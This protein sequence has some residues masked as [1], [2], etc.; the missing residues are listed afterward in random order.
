[1]KVKIE[2]SIARGEIKAP[3]SKSYAHRYL[4]ASALSRGES[5]VEGIINSDDMEATVRCASALGVSIKRLNNTVTVTSNGVTY[6][7][8][9]R[10]LCC[11]ES[12]STLR[13]FIPIALALGGINTFYGTERLISRGISVYEEICKEQCIDVE[14]SNDKIIFKGKLH[15]GTFNVRGDIS[16]QFIT[17]L[18]FALPLLDGSSVINVTTE[19]ESASYIDVT[20]DVL[21]RFGIEVKKEK[22][23]FFVKGNQEYKRTDACVEGDMSNAA[24]L[25]AFN[26]LGGDVSVIGLNPQSKQG[27]AVYA[28]LMEELKHTSPVIS[29][30]NCPDLA[31]VLFAVASSCNGAVF[32]DTKRLRI[33]ESDRANAMALELEKF[34]ASVEVLENSVVV[35]KGKLKPPTQMLFGHNDHRIVM[36]LSVISSIYGGEIEGAQAINKSYPD[37]FEDIKKLGVKLK[38]YD[39]KI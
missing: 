14:K 32:T 29:L 12:G 17:G 7:N 21:S 1:M 31:P 11:N 5:T 9:S 2:P 39:E 16:S 38:V 10:T 19:L 20:I 33:K 25:D 18:L 3:P 36:A 28:A 4:I 23:T 6:Q 22:N 27:D 34:G 15:S 8:E 30:K 37:F 35:H 13:F 26:V 24:F